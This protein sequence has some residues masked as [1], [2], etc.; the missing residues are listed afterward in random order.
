M[1][2]LRLRF[3]IAAKMAVW[4]SLNLAFLAAGGW[5]F[6][7]S[8]FHSGFDS[9]LA[10]AA[11]PRVEAL[12]DTI[13]R[14]LRMT[15]PSRWNETLTDLARA[16]GVP[17]AVYWNTGEWLAGPKLD[18]PEPL[19]KQLAQPANL[20]PPPQR[21]PP[22]PLR[23]NPPPRGNPPP[24][25]PGNFA[26]PETF[27]GPPFGRPDGP[28][29]RPP[30]R[31]FGPDSTGD[32][33]PAKEWP[34]FLLST[35][36][37]TAYWIGLR[38][39]LVQGR[40]EEA[41]TLLIRCD[42]LSAGGLLLETRP[43]VLA[44]GGAV[45]VSVLFWLPFAIGLTR[46]LR[47]VTAATVQIARGDFDVR[48]PAYEHDE[49]GQLALSVN[50]MAGQLDT[51]VRGQ[52][53]FLGDI[54]HELCSPIA[55]MQAALAIVEARA[56]DE[57][58]ARYVG[59]LREELDDIAHLVDE[60]LNFSRATAQ[61]EIKMQAVSLNRLV[62]ETVAREA[63]GA[64]VECDVPTGLVAQGEPRLLARA[65]GNV[66]R[67]AVRYAGKAGPIVISAAPQGDHINLVVAD[68]G[69]GVPVESLPRLFDAFY[70][71]D[72]ARTRDT[73]GTGLGLAIVK[74]CIEACRGQVAA[75]LGEPHGLEVCFKLPSAA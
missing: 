15:P 52:K 6:F 23:E 5:L 67:N 58:Q 35:T 39:P 47:R 54:A 34:K 8:Q 22:P 21:N 64:E 56:V 73:G 46:H 75:R 3:P 69:P 71:P 55:R 74:T 40:R 68:S 14:T 57:K 38:A 26:G 24:R 31:D 50:T 60:L 28:P 63:P 2:R 29:G 48:V 10:A 59:T 25:P 19:L 33:P 27:D 66:V 61:R 17:M 7:R 70:R 9:F 11:A 43:F 20:R 13:V 51:L 65:L 44:G 49:L 41:V 42:S 4:L 53:R 36:A 12:G 16:H 62:A 32:D 18:L 72:V 37:P 1:P 30:R 45:L